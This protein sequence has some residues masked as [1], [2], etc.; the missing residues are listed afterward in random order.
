M[1][2]TSAHIYALENKAHSLYCDYVEAL[3]VYGDEAEAQRLFTECE[4]IEEELRAARN[5][6]AVLLQQAE[7]DAYYERL[8]NALIATGRKVRR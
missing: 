6:L 4:K 1:T 5:E 8:E 3:Y 7:E 2:K